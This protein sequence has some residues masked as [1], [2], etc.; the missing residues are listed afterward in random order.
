MRHLWCESH[1]SLIHYLAFLNME[2]KQKDYHSCTLNSKWKHK[3]NKYLITQGKTLTFK[4]VLRIF[5]EIKQYSSSPTCVCYLMESDGDFISSILLLVMWCL[6]NLCKLI[7]VDYRV[8][9]I[10]LIRT[11]LFLSFIQ[12]LFM[13]HRKG[14]F[15]K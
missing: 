1:W 9:A 3:K 2:S 15:S 11:L 6:L 14:F 13:K 4:I 10:T 5:M 12:I 7:C 8:S